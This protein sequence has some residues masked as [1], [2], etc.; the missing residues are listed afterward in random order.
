MRRRRRSNVAD[1]PTSVVEPR[2]RKRQVTGSTGPKATCRAARPASLARS[3][4]LA[5]DFQ[6]VTPGCASAMRRAGCVSRPVNSAATTV[7]PTVPRDSQFPTG[8]VTFLFTDIEGSTT[9]W[10]QHPDAMQAALARHDSLMRHAIESSNGYVV[11]STG[12]G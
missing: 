11:K 10:E 3:Q 6:E 12:D 1:R 5:R 4:R 7:H 8:T 2:S 9:L